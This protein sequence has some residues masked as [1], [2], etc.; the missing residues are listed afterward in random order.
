ML[1]ANK[2]EDCFRKKKNNIYLPDK[3]KKAM[4]LVIFRWLGYAKSKKIKN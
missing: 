3:L 2:K 1:T 4:F